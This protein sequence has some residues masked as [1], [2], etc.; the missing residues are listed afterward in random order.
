[1]KK[2]GYSFKSNFVYGL[3]VVIPLGVLVLLIAKVVEI[4]QSVAL[5]LNLDST[6]NAAFAIVTALVLLLLVCFGIGTMVRT[7][8][9]SWSFEKIE[10]AIFRRLPG[11][12]FV[13]NILKGFAKEK[14]AYPAV[15]V[16]LHGPGSAVF[17]LV[18]EEN[19][20]GVLTVFIPSAPALTVG[21]LHVVQRDRVT[22]LEAST[23]DV[24]NSISQWGIGSQKIL[25]DFRP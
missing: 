19:Q 8:I 6:A 4:L 20:N 15:M 1:M 9:G 2:S 16:H 17:G 22:F 25:G 12:E 18:M 10:Q 23:P 24:I 14:D 5:S 7:R 13:G 11:Y 3:M 21:S